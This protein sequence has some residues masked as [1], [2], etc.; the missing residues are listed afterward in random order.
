MH[1][2]KIVTLLSFE[3]P[4]TAKTVRCIYLENQPWI[5]TPSLIGLDSDNCYYYPSM[6]N[7]DKFNGCCNTLLIRLEYIF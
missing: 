1:N 6:V 7:L 5:A 4:L 2:E 3:T